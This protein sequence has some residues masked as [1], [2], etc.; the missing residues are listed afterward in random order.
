VHTSKKISEGKFPQT[1]MRKSWFEMG[2]LESS[3][4]AMSREIF[5]LFNNVIRE[6]GS[7]NAVFSGLKEGVIVLGSDGRIAA[8]NPAVEKI[9]GIRSGE[10]CKK[11]VLEALRNN[12]ISAIVERSVSQGKEIEEEISIVAPV[13]ASFSVYAGP[14]RDKEG[15][16]IGGICVLHDITKLKKLENYRSEFVA[17]VSHELKTPLTAI[18]NYSETLINGGLEDR[19]NSKAFLLKIEKHADSLSALIDDILEISRLE[20]GRNPGERKDINVNDIINRSVEM[21][22]DKAGKKGINIEV[23]CEKG[24]RIKSFE[25]YL[26]RAV[27]NLI[28][29]A[30]NYSGQGGSIRVECLRNDNNIEISVS[31]NGIGIPKESLER[32]FE[33]FYRVDP[34]RSRETGGTGLGLSIVKHIMELNGGRVKVESRVGTGSKFTLIFPVR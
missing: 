30:I 21:V 17:N 3:I 14:I 2:A 20:S 8:A 24:I 25:D 7:S 27:S 34:A 4:E 13:G 29:N 6:Q 31:D 1:I 33:R 23:K 12:E 9:F 32:I 22:L 10:I 5:D 26:S 19:E 11:T 28:D 15:N 18:K 16:V